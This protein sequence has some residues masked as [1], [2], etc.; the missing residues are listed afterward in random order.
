MSLHDGRLRST[1]QEKNKVGK[2]DHI[3]MESKPAVQRSFPKGPGLAAIAAVALRREWGLLPTSTGK[4]RRTVGVRLFLVAFFAAACASAVSAQTAQPAQPDGQSA[5][6]PGMTVW[7]TESGGREQ[8]ARVVAVSGDA[9]TTAAGEERRTVPWTDIARVRARRSDSVL[10][11]ALIGAGAAVASGLFYCR[12]ME[13]WDICNDPGPLF[14]IGAIGA[15]IGIGVDA[16]IRG[17]TTIYEAAHGSTR[18]HAAPIIGPH[19]AGVRV[20]VSF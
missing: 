10:N 20:S 1:S 13:P 3:E 12:M 9:V 18:L 5:L 16:L 6:T 15:G 2:R 8:K 4:T 11:G 7:I 14:R 17:R 19:T